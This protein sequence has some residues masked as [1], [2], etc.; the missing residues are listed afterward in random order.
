MTRRSIAIATAILMTSSCAYAQVSGPGMSNPNFGIGMTSP[1][2]MSPSGTSVG[3]TGIPLGATE[4][5]T[6]GVSMGPSA[7]FGFASSAACAGAGAIGTANAMTGTPTSSGLFDASGVGIS[8]GTTQL[9]ATGSMSTATASVSTATCGQ[10]STVGNATASQSSPST[11]ATSQLGMPTIPLGSTELS[12][13]GVSPA[14]CPAAG[15]TAPSTMG[16]PMS[17]GAC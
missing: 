13:G 4:L 16:M 10:A 9:G 1:L 12:N 14:P 7:P 3:P 6:P 5:A 11:P 2:G 8:T 15:F 17:S